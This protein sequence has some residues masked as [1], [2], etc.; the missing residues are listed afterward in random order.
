MRFQACTIIT[1]NYLPQA[2]VLYRSFRQFRPEIRFSA[3]VF[4][5]ERGAVDEPFDLVAL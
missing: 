2:R 3:L 1:R 5:A 4:D